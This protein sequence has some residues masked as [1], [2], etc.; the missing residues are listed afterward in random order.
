VPGLRPALTHAV[1]HV[2]HPT[3]ATVPG[4]VLSAGCCVQHVV[5]RP[6]IT[7]RQ[8]LQAG[9]LA[10]LAGVLRP[11]L[12]QYPERVLFGTDA[13]AGGPDAGWELS[14]WVAG[15]TARK[16]L[17][18]ALT[19]MVRDGE[20]T[21]ARAR[22]VGRMVLRDNAAKLYRLPLKCRPLCSDASWRPR[23][24]RWPPLHPDPSTSSR[25]PSPRCSRRCARGG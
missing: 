3:L 9:A 10:T 14:A 7:R 25:P 23:P 21:M 8:V 20:I 24:A 15:R 2:S 4:P 16:A 12:E 13:F 17:G 11:W 19:A 6:S 18:I 5:Q 22:E 1:L